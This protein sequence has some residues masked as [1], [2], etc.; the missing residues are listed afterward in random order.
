MKIVVCFKIMPDYGRLS[1]KDWV[2]D[3]AFFVDTAFVRRIFNCYDESALEMALALSD[4]MGKDSDKTQLTAVTVDDPKSDLFL[5]HLLATGYDHAVRIHC[6]DGIDLRFNP[7]AIAELIAAYVRQNNQ[8]LVLAGVQ[9]GDGDNGQTGPL[10]AE[11][12]GW[13]CIREVIRVAITDRPDILKIFS[14][15]NGATV[16]RTVRLPLVL[17][18][19][20]SQDSPFLGFPS[21]KQKLAARKKSIMPLSCQA[22]GID[23]ETLADTDKTLTALERPRTKHSCVF[24]DG[25]DPRTLARHLYDQYLKDRMN[26]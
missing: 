26:R 4:R 22:L 24:L 6:R 7:S 13:P 11:Y 20:Q 2:W 19:G 21:L 5:T 1:E 25:S 10:V 12:L 17:T 8:Q 14:L 16:V 23:D 3:D 9:G 18:I 15:M